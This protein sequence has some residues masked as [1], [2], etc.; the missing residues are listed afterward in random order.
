MQNLYDLIEEFNPY[1]LFKLN[2][3]SLIN[4][5]IEKL[6]IKN[7]LPDQNRFY[8]IDINCDGPVEI[9]YS[10]YDLEWLAEASEDLSYSDYSSPDIVAEYLGELREDIHLLPYDSFTCFKNLSAFDMI[11]EVAFV[12]SMIRRNLFSIIPYYYKIYTWLI[13][14]SKV[15]EFVKAVYL[16]NELT[17]ELIN[18]YAFQAKLTAELFCSQGLMAPEFENIKYFLTMK[19]N[20]HPTFLKTLKIVFDHIVD[21]LKLDLNG[22]VFDDMAH[23][24][25][26]IV[27]ANGVI[28]A[29]NKSVQKFLGERDPYIFN[30]DSDA[31]AQDAIMSDKTNDYIKMIYLEYFCILNRGIASWPN[32]KNTNYELG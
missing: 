20:P 4:S 11:F 17:K 13:T 25:R 29:D 27:D 24:M 14:N 9:K 1:E 16:A 31:L 2:R 32:S 19:H 15:F 21:F 7:Y 10:R 8:T 5:T 3:E 22:V 26:T 18:E 28:S 6:G 30:N 12:D 23:L